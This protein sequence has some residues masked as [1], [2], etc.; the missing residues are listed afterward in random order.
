MA[1]ETLDNHGEMNH[2]TEKLVSAGD[3]GSLRDGCRCAEANQLE[4][5]YTYWGLG[6]ADVTYPGDLER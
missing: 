6:Y 3:L 2:A 4:G 5:W 1:K